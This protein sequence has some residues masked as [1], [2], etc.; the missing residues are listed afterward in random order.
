MSTKNTAENTRT[1][2]IPP[3]IDK[4]SMDEDS[5]CPECFKAVGDK[6]RYTVVC[7]LGKNPEGLT[8]SAITDLLQLTQPTVTHHLNILKSIDA[9][10]VEQKGRERV[11]TLNRDAHCFEECKIPY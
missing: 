10:F 7:R 2:P 8:V 9:V 1:Y 3:W 4:S 5:L 6:A 11:Y